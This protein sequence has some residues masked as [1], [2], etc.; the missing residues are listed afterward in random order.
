M[1]LFVTDLDPITREPTSGWAVPGP[2]ATYYMNNVIASNPMTVRSPNMYGNKNIWYTEFL[3]MPATETNDLVAMRIEQARMA[4]LT[5]SRA[6]FT[7]AYSRTLQVLP[8]ALSKMLENK[9]NLGAMAKQIS[10]WSK[11]LGSSPLMRQKISYDKS[12]P[13]IPIDLSPGGVMSGVYLTDFNSMSTKVEMPEFLATSYHMLEYCTRLQMNYA[14]AKDNIKSPRY[15]GGDKMAFALKLTPD[16]TGIAEALTTNMLNTNMPYLTDIQNNFFDL[17]VGRAH[18]WYNV[19]NAGA[20]LVDMNTNLFGYVTSFYMQDPL[21]NSSRLDLDGL[22]Y[23][24]VFQPKNP[25][26]TFN[27]LEEV[28]QVCAGSTFF[29]VFQKHSEN[30]VMF[31]FPIKINSCE[32]TL[33]DNENRMYENRA[34]DY[35]TMTVT[36][37]KQYWN[38]AEIVTFHRSNNLVVLNRPAFFC[39]L[40]ANLTP[41]TPDFDSLM[42]FRSLQFRNSVE[43]DWQFEFVTYYTH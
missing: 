14:L 43:F 9:Y 24:D 31:N 42:T 40:L 7:G 8:N 27:S 33:G 23:V 11:Y 25:S 3:D 35:D 1:Q 36:S 20:A 26:Y 32:K 17:N 6:Q 28:R 41:F 15:T 13:S 21:P 37:L 5:I 18:P 16:S 38:Y 2:N 19:Y 29:D 30:G 12:L 39:P 10:F 34:I 22:K 4:V